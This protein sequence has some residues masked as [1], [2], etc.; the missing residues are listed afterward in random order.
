[1]NRKELIERL[2]EIDT[3]LKDVNHIIDREYRDHALP[4]ELAKIKAEKKNLLKEQK[5]L[6]GAAHGDDITAVS[7]AKMINKVL[8]YKE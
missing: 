5:D 2:E 8:S 7:V 6:V 1:M 4:S 3:R